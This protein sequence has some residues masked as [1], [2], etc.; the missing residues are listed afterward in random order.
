MVT[1][2]IRITKRVGSNPEYTDNGNKP[3]P[4]TSVEAQNA[5]HMVTP[6]RI[7]KMLETRGPLA[8]RFITQS[9]SEEIPYFKNLSTSKQRRLIMNV[10]ETGYE[11]QSLIFEKIGWGLWT[12]RKVSPETFKQERDVTNK[13]NAKVRDNSNNPNAPEIKRR[14]SSNTNTRKKSLVESMSAPL[15]PRLRA[16]GELPNGARSVVYIDEN[17]LQTDEEDNDVFSEEDDE[18]HGTHNH[19]NN[20]NNSNGNKIKNEHEDFVRE[21]IKPNGAFNFSRRK[22]SV[23]YDDTMPEALEQE[24]LAQ[25]IRPL[26]KNKSR[27]SSSKGRP[28]HIFNMGNNSNNNNNNNNNNSNNNNNNSNNNSVIGSPLSGKHILD[29]ENIPPLPRILYTGEDSNVSPNNNFPLRK[30][31]ISGLGNDLKPG[32]NSFSEDVSRRS[33]SRLSVSKESGIRSTL[34][35]TVNDISAQG[36]NNSATSLGT[37]SQMGAFQSPGLPIIEQRDQIIAIANNNNINNNNNNKKNISDTNIPLTNNNIVE[38][39]HSETDEEDW[40]N[41]GAESLR[42]MSNDI[43]PISTNKQ[44]THTNHTGDAD[45]AARVLLSLK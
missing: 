5:V 42:T 43:S 28:V 15:S 8:I 35:H 11:E 26:L 34:F 24:M 31:S 3:L 12:V 16:Q 32:R 36:S 25:K 29:N 7:S 45:D 27:R 10:M 18:G 30:G 4:I 13:L 19:N 20:G 37:R 9:L 1:E 33:S 44:V 41:I 14:L 21:M 23:V 39:P 2:Q 17:V 22:S 38:S 6:E 40:A